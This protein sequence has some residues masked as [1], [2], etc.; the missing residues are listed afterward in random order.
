MKS[1]CQK[2]LDFIPRLSM[3]LF[4]MG[5]PTYRRHFLAHQEYAR[6]GADAGEKHGP[7]LILPWI[8]TA[9]FRKLENSSDYCIF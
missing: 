7:F 6:I 4:Q 8:Q 1:Q 3:L 9:Y 5:Q 2:P